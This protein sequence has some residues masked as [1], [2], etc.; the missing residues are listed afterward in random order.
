[1]EYLLDAANRYLKTAWCRKYVIGSY[2]GLRVMKRS[3]DLSPSALSRDW[4]LKTLN[5]GLRCSVGGK[6]TSAREDACA[7]VDA[8]CASLGVSKACESGAR[9]LSWAPQGGFEAWMAEGVGRARR[10]GIDD[11][12]A[13]WL[14]RRHGLRSEQASR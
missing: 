1:V 6:V 14:L 5:N 11:E 13:L 4:E 8:V 3:D 12:A 2:A 10:F 9:A 7:I